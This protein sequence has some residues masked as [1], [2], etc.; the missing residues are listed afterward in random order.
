LCA[1][2]KKQPDKMKDLIGKFVSFKYR[3]RK[4]IIS[5]FLLDYNEDWTLIKYNVVDYIIDGYRILKSNL[6]LSYKRDEFEIFREK[7]LNSKGLK[8]SKID[9][10]P[11]KNIHQT[12]QLI[13]DRFGAFQIEKKDETVCYIG[14]FVKIEKGI[15]TIQEIDDKAVWVDNDKYRI[16]SIRLFEFDTDYINTLISYNK[17]INK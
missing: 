4:D 14:K 7:V 10:F 13:S 17:R 8:P 11:I 1:I 3:D 15:L 9:K 6:I 5:G 2:V 12:L 16:S